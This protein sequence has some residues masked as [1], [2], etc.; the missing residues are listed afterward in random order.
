MC[1]ISEF[2]KC[3]LTLRLCC[4]KHF[5]ALHSVTYSFLVCT[6]RSGITSVY[7]LLCLMNHSLASGCE[8]CNAYSGTVEKCIFTVTMTEVSSILCTK[9]LCRV[10]AGLKKVASCFLLF[11]SV[12]VI[13][14][15]IL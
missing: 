12:T 6:L 13:I 3:L 14:H 8:I 2:I 11:F 1:I 9:L 5:S 4:Y 15:F 10:S 7:F